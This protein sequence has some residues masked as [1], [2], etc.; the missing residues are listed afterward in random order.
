LHLLQTKAQSDNGDAL[1]GEP[2]G[3]RLFDAMA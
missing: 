3:S 1:D 2:R